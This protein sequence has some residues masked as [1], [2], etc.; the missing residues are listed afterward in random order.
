MK[1]PEVIEGIITDIAYTII[2]MFCL[3]IIS[4]CIGKPESGEEKE[5]IQKLSQ[6]WYK[7][8]TVDIGCKIRMFSPDSGYAV[9]NGR[10]DTE[11]KIYRFSNGSWQAFYSY[12]Y[13]DFPFFAF[14]EP[15][16]IW[17]IHH[18]VH[19]GFYRPILVEFSKDGKKELPLPP[20]MWDKTDYAM[21]K[22]MA[23][24]K[25]GKAWMGGQ[26]GYLLYY[27]GREWRQAE[28]PII[29]DTL[30]NL[31]DGDINDIEIASDGTGW[32]VGKKGIILR[33]RE[34]KW[35]RVESPTR[36]TLFSISLDDYGGGWI[37][38]DRGTLL[39]LQQGRWERVALP[40][41]NALHS[42]RSL[43]R[44]S[45]V[46][47]GMNSTILYY[48]AGAIYEDEGL[49]QYE[50]NF[51]D[52]DFLK[53]SDNT[54]SYWIIGSE[55]IYTT[56]QSAGFSFTNVSV[57]TTLPGEGKSGLFFRNNIGSPLQLLIFREGTPPQL[58]QMENG[59]FVRMPGNGGINTFMTEISGSA[60]SD[61]NNDGSGDVFLSFDQERF[62]CF[63][64]SGSGVFDE[65]TN[66]SGIRFNSS[67]PFT[68]M[69]SRFCDFDADGNVD[70]YV[71]SLEGEDYLFRNNG[72]GNFSNIFPSTGITKFE[73]IKT[74][75]VCIAD[76]DTNGLA[77]IFFPYQV[78]ADGYNGELYLNEGK[79]KFRKVTNTSFL[80]S[81]GESASSLGAI[82]GD[83]TN[84]GLP[85][86]IMHNQKQVPWLF[87]NEGDGRF[88][89]TTIGNDILF[90]P[91]YTPAVLSSADVNND[92]RLDVF[93]SS[94][95]FLNDFHHTGGFREV[96][97]QTGIL[98]T[99]NPVFVDF[100]DDGDN[101]LFLG[102]SRYAIGRDAKTVLYQN[103]NSSVNSS[104]VRI[105]ADQSNRAGTG[106]VVRVVAEGA[107]PEFPRVQYL[108]MGLSGS[109]VVPQ[110]LSEAIFAIPK[111]G[112]V[113][114]SVTF[115]SGIRHII[116]DIRAGQSIEVFESAF[117]VRQ[118]V[119]LSKHLHRRILTVNLVTEQIR[120]L[121]L[122][123]LC[124]GIFL[125]NNRFKWF[126]K[127]EIAGTALLF[128][129]LYIVH[130]YFIDPE[131]VSE[132]MLYFLL[133][134]FSI[135]IL[136]AIT[137]VVLKKERE[138]HYLSHFRIKDEI[139]RGGMGVVYDAI[140]VLNKR[141]VAVKVLHTAMMNDPENRK[142]FR[143]EGEI[144]ASLTHK[145]IVRIFETGEYNGKSFIAM[146]KLT[147]GSLSDY[148][149]RTGMIEI[150]E[151]IKLMQE[152]TQ[153]LIEVHRNN[154]VHRDLKSAN[155]LL[156]ANGEPKIMDFGLSKSPLVTSMTSLGTVIGTLGYCAPEQVT[157]AFSD[158][159]SDIFSLGVIFYEMVTG[160]IPFTGENE[161]ALIHSIFSFTPE[162]PSKLNP[163]IPATLDSVIMKCI[164]KLPDD[165][166]TSATEVYK[167]LSELSITGK[168]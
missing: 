120:L 54:I 165:R 8:A 10:G 122:L 59:R 99:G 16:K 112:S 115:P 5:H 89:K 49:K 9:S 125:L 55:G 50:D 95:L 137:G 34:N 82:T 43:G 27:D 63:T 71:S 53:T 28:S 129:L 168:L 151:A 133:P 157:N 19:K 48:L 38:G 26:Q 97:Q 101:D 110:N 90:H 118:A 45:A 51:Y 149:R 1:L 103:N 17:L 127:S 140:D 21:L 93:I 3:L 44:D 69:T 94:K 30:Q 100:D 22:T 67:S 164:A 167:A 31:L 152:I 85:D 146:E 4:G 74:F 142:R 86:I 35:E 162:V 159:R 150:S 109:A 29:R 80:S 47:V 40:V 105:F 107:E 135:F 32:A 72:A 68:I 62:G 70:L 14:P 104:K 7:Q 75:G 66:K 138:A 106:A 128:V 166:F 121:L 78:P 143:Q 41:V 58:H 25:N 57:K 92:G 64:G 113:T 139:G 144:L 155:I 76:F 91:D 83:F 77:D 23:F 37:S 56:S 81:D 124:A 102:M 134:Q 160:V 11:G 153:G 132:W 111:K 108:L 12:P 119:L 141:P 145:N 161:I 148:I 6:I 42:V 116:K 154:I 147:G 79:M 117:P 2:C 36:A 130:C 87:V 18:L 163:F 60:F 123:L 136:I 65:F 126:T 33:L 114:L 88:R 20:L 15:N 52:I 46:I 131:S 98:S 39:R 84:D 61:I 96:T 13:S 158:T 24:D 73:S 156:D